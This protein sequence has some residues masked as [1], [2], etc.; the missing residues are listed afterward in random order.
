VHT[1]KLIIMATAQ[2]TLDPK[3]L[4]GANTVAYY[5]GYNWDW[6]ANIRLGP[7]S[8][9]GEYTEP[10]NK[11]YYLDYTRPKELTRCIH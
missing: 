6:V 3:Y 2:V 9:Q 10:H 4:L 8:L 5:G 11:G 1:Q 7:K